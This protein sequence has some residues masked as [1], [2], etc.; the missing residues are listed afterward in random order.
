MIKQVLL[1]LGCKEIGN[2]L[3]QQRASCY[4]SLG[5]TVGLQEG[6]YLRQF[7]LARV[8]KRC[9][10]GLEEAG[11]C[12]S[13]WQLLHQ[14]CMGS[15]GLGHRSQCSLLLQ[16]SGLANIQHLLLTERDFVLEHFNCP[17]AT[18]RHPCSELGMPTPL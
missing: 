13:S 8:R 5:R 18:L 4:C 6:L 3:R 12:S 1:H 16:H 11:G 9:S 7:L 10:A 17:S 2:P 15:A 14:S